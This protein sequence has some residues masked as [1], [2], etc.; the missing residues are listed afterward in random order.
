[1]KFTI[2]LEPTLP[3]HDESRVSGSSALRLDPERIVAL[4]FEILTE[5]PDAIDA[6][7]HAR[8]SILREEWTLG[9]SPDEPSLGD[10]TFSASGIVWLVRR[11]EIESCLAKVEELV[12]RTNRA[13]EEIS[14]R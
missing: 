7:R 6:L 14:S 9:H 1:M 4:R 3:E 5:E 10:A 13:I 2:G 8:R 12:A 11:Q